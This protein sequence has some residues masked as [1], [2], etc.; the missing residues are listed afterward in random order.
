MTDPELGFRFISW[1]DFDKALEFDELLYSKMF[2]LAKDKV[3]DELSHHME[4]GGAV[5]YFQPMVEKEKNS[6]AGNYLYQMYEN[7]KKK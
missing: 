7:E 5:N 3:D 1:D 6:N 2:N 4:L